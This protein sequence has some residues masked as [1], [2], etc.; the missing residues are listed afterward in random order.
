MK[1]GNKMHTWNFSVV[2]IEKGRISYTVKANDKKKAI[3]KGFNVLKR[4]GLSYANSFDC[5]LIM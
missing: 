1:R 3:E 2:T 4:K 5:R